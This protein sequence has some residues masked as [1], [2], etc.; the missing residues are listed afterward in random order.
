MMW[1]GPTGEPHYSHQVSTA[2]P[3][4]RD[5]KT[6]HLVLRAPTAV[7]DHW[8]KKLRHIKESNLGSG[9]QTQHTSDPLHCPQKVIPIMFHI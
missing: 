4:P 9:T 3:G 5:I 8:R 2:L 1:S 7:L 6:D